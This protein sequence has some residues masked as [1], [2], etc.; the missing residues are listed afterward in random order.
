MADLNFLTYATVEQSVKDIIGD[1]YDPGVD[2]D[3]FNPWIP[4]TLTP[5]LVGMPRGWPAA[6]LRLTQQ[7]P[8]MT[9]LLAPIPA[10]IETG[11]LKARRGPAPA[12]EI[13]TAEERDEQDETLGVR[14]LAQTAAL[15]LPEGARLVYDVH[16]DDFQLGGQTFRVQDFTFAAPTSD[17]TVY[18]TSVERI[19]EPPSTGS[20]VLV[21]LVP[22]AYRIEDG[23]LILSSG[24]IDLGPGVELPS[25]PGGGGTTHTHV[26][27]SPAATWTI[28]NPL[29]SST[30]PGGVLLVVGGEVVEADVDLSNLAN[31][32]V[33]FATPQSGRALIS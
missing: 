21:R 8:P 26:Q 10:R 18:L 24:G 4:V 16:Y 1:T 23:L 30:Y 12:G 17:T 33:T 22:D 29:G 13:P 9:I 15:E 14:I 6:E 5:R 2:P 25:G 28:P 11:V 7:D 20:D 3:Y 27:S 31:I 19:N 32:V